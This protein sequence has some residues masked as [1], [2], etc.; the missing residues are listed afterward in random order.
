MW[1]FILRTSTSA[2]ASDGKNKRLRFPVLEY[3]AGILTRHL[4]SSVLTGFSLAVF[5]IAALK[6]P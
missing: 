5:G 6:L 4:P 2:L 3:L 1:D